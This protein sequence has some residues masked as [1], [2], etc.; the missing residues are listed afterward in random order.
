VTGLL[1]ILV[2][3][4]SDKLN[5]KMVTVCGFLFFAIGNFGY[6]A[7]THPYQLFIL[8][9]IFALGSACLA[10]PLSALFAAFIQKEK[11]GL[12]WALGSGGTKIVVG[13]SVLIGTLI[14]SN[15]GFKVLFI[16]MGTIQLIAAGIQMRLKED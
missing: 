11:E 2:G 9:I 15:F 6:L 8:Q 14:V 4:V 13:L 1:I 7:I 5:K 10:A 3:K 16:L 12:Q